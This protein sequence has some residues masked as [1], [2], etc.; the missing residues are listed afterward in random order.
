MTSPSSR[1]SPLR[2]V[3]LVLLLLGTLATLG[4]AG[5]WTAQSLM[6]NRALGEGRAVADMAENVGRWASQYGGV[7]VRTQGVQAKLPGSFLT[8]SSYSAT[9]AGTSLPSSPAPAERVSERDMLDRIEMYYWKNPAL[10]QREVADVVTASGSR[11][12]YRMT[13]RS[14]LNPNNKPGP[15]ELEALDAIQ[16]GFGKDAPSANAPADKV[17]A[18]FWKVDAGRVYYARAIVAQAS[19]LKCHDQAD[20]APEFLKTNSLFNGGGGFGYEAG[21]PVGIISVTV[22]LTDAASAL[23]TNVPPQAWAALTAAALAALA[24]LV[25]MLRRS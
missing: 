25:L 1:S 24:L 8:R 5:W 21:K 11:V 18:E 15:F 16:A 14:V 22:P 9:A 3:L 13:A 7:H 4:L 19:C 10:I 2:S 20:K 17:P 23:E 12:Q 6:L